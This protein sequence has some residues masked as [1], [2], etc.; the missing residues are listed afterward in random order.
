MLLLEY[1]FVGVIVAVCAIFSIWRLLSVRARVK[2]LEALAALPGHPGARSL[3]AMRQRMLAGLGSGCGSCT[4][5]ALNA[6]AQVANQS[7]GVPRR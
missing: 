5:S 7:S 4:Q 6:S 1:L 3:T 2:V